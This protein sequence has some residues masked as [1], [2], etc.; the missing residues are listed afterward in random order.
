VLLAPHVLDWWRN[1]APVG[2]R[3][4]EAG[5]QGALLR[6]VP[7]CFNQL[8]CFDPRVPHGVER[9]SGVGGDP[10]RARVALHGWFQDPWPC[11][12]QGGLVGAHGAEDDI[13]ARVTKA[14]VADGELAS[15]GR[16]TGPLVV[17]LRCDAGGRV[18]PSSILASFD[19]VEPDPAHADD[20]AR[21]DAARLLILEKVDAVL[22]ALQLPSA[23][24]GSSV[25]IPLIFE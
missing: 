5:T 9:V 23:P 3:R 10:R 11:V 25:T 4:S 24:T 14:L 1:F 17:Q 15:L 8:V 20:A 12:T 7:P 21:P 6:K 22:R 2:N 19:S 16:C 18:V 13:N